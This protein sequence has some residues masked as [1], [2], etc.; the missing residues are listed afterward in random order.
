MWLSIEFMESVK[1]MVDGKKIFLNISLI[2][3]GL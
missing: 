2:E 3:T 1:A